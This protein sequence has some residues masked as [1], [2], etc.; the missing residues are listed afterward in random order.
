MNIK[1]YILQHKATCVS[2]KSLDSTEMIFYHVWSN[3]ISVYG[4]SPN[5]DTSFLKWRVSSS[6]RIIQCHFMS[7]VNIPL[8]VHNTKHKKSRSSTIPCRS[9]WQNWKWWLLFAG[10]SPYISCT[11]KYKQF[12]FAVHIKQHSWERCVSY[13][14]WQAPVDGSARIPANTFFSF[15]TLHLLQS[16]CATILKHL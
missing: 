2:W 10:C 4:S 11:W 15:C 13:A 8:S 9:Q 16:M 12:L 7:A 3:Y 14:T 6:M 1:D 5:T